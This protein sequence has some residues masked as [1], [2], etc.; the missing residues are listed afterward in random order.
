MIGP[1]I[2]E[3]VNRLRNFVPPS[4][5]III[6]QENEITDYIQDENLTSGSGENSI[7]GELLQ[8][9][10][11][12]NN[13]STNEIENIAKTDEISENISSEKNISI[14]IDIIFKEHNK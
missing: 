9:I 10:Q 2:H 5:R 4:N 12:F 11:Y 1:S 14:I 8:I 13:M 7:H 3:V 6:N